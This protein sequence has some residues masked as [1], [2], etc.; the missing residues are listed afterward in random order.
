[1]YNS[2]V[3]CHVLPCFEGSFHPWKEFLTN[4][5]HFPTNN[6]FEDFPPDCLKMITEQ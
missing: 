6:Y 1:M 3:K 5:H 4:F 2:G